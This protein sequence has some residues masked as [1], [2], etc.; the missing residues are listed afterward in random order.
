MH[1]DGAKV[2]YHRYNFTI[3][4]SLLISQAEDCCTSV[5]V[6]VTLGAPWDLGSRKNLAA[7]SAT[8]TSGGST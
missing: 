6:R 2:N 5:M 4:V 3:E 7:A 8:L 1:T